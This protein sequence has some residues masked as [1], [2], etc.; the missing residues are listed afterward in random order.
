MVRMPVS[1]SERVHL[2]AR[3]RDVGSSIGQLR[4]RHGQRIEALAQQLDL[5]SLCHQVAGEQMISRSSGRS[6]AGVRFILGERLFRCFDQDA[7]IARGESE[8]RITAF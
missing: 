7:G 1:L 5:A 3:R 4:L 2:V 8:V 6:G